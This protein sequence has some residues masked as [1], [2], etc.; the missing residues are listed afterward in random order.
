MRVLW[1]LGGNWTGSK[2]AKHRFNSGYSTKMFRFSFLQFIHHRK[3]MLRV[4]RISTWFD[5]ICHPSSHTI[6]THSPCQRLKFSKGLR[7]TCDFGGLLVPGDKNG[8]KKCNRR[9]WRILARFGDLGEFHKLS[10]LSVQGC[11]NFSLKKMVFSPLT[12]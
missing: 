1:H 6:S 4:R 9:K 2:P 11:G 3:Y 7:A 10:K 8:G 5:S 12:Q